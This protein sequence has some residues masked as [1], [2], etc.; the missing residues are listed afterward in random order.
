[1]T[2]LILALLIASGAMIGSSA[3]PT[4]VAVSNPP[5]ECRGRYPAL[6]TAGTAEAPTPPTAVAPARWLGV[7]GG[8]SHRAVLPVRFFPS[9]AEQPV[10]QQPAARPVTAASTTGQSIRGVASWMPERYGARYLALPEGAGHR[11]TVCG[12]AACVTMTS[13]DAGPSLAM[14]RKGRIVDLGVKAWEYVTG[15]PRSRGIA[16]VAVRRMP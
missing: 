4:T 6:T 7:A 12:A 10:R 13:N 2:R 1:M 11:V 14:Q 8:A 15:L 3:V 16:W 5:A 9:A